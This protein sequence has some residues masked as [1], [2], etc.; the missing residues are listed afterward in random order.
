MGIRYTFL[1]LTGLLLASC[2]NDWAMAQFVIRETE[3]LARE[4]EY[5]EVFVQLPSEVPV[6]EQLCAIA[7]GDGK[8]IPVDFHLTE[9]DQQVAEACF[10]VSV[11]ANG[12]RHASI[13][14]CDDSTHRI[15]DGLSVEGNG[16]EIK[17]SNRFFIA[18]MGSATNRP[19]RS[20]V[21]GHLTSLVLNKFDNIKLERTGAKIHWAP[22]LGSESVSY[23]TMA[24]LD[25]S[26]HKVSRGAYITRIRKEGTIAGFNGFELWGEYQFFTGLPYF[27]F[28]SEMAFAEDIELNLLR[29]DEM[30]MDS[31]FT[32]IAFRR[33]SG[34]YENYPLYD[35]ATFT[36]LEEN[37]LEADAP[38][39]FFYNAREGYAFG[40]I[41]LEMDNLNG[42]GGM[43]PLY[44]PHTKISQGANQ[45]RYW[46]RRLIHDHTTLVPAGSRYQEKNAYVIFE[47]QPNHSR[48]W[49]DT[50]R[51]KLMNPL[52]V[53]IDGLGK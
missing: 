15:R 47:Y 45:G 21:P 35:D 23:K 7:G 17:I 26:S 28:E 1:L 10:P 5:I 36:Y 42:N 13:I 43:S 18:D 29:N 46:N 41:R 14:I 16:L 9:A 52:K 6:P 31:L 34:K 49:L 20:F 33:T 50:L 51:M 27:M 11:V 8:H 38:W 12:I 25:E 3:G 30:T 48:Y 53:N 44:E 24:S 4:R 19:D 32:H 37:H 22:N 40:V 2:D 39:L